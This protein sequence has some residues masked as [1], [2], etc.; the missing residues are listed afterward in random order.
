[1]NYSRLFFQENKLVEIARQSKGIYNGMTNDNYAFDIDLLR[2]IYKWSYKSGADNNSK[3]IIELSEKVGVTSDKIQYWIDALNDLDSF[4]ISRNELS[5]CANVHV[6]EFKEP[7]FLGNK[8]V[9][10][11]YIP[12][13]TPYRE[14]CISQ[15][16]FFQKFF[17]YNDYFSGLKK[18]NDELYYGELK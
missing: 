15:N 10:W 7:A 12:N 18:I 1:M 9:G 4:L 3:N 8:A 16:G 5:G 2:K 6:S 11:F 13:N 17:H 14:Y